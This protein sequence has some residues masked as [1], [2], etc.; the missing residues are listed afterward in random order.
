MRAPLVLLL[1]LACLL[2]F[3]VGWL[4]GGPRVLL[5]L[6]NKPKKAPPPI[7]V[8]PGPTPRLVAGDSPK[9]TRARSTD[10][11]GPRQTPAGIRR[12]GAIDYIAVFTAPAEGRRNARLDYL[13]ESGEQEDEPPNRG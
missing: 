13:L 9:A 11:N 8:P 7:L 2:G 1:L 3:A 10:A 4:G 12:S 5:R 6:L